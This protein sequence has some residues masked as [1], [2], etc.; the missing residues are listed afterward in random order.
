VGRRL[1]LG[2]LGLY[3]DAARAMQ[4]RQ[5]VGRARRLVP[6]RVLLAWS[7]PA[8][9]GEFH[10]LAKGLA[11]EA[12]SQS[13]P[14]PAAH[15]AREFAAVGARRAFS[16]SRAFWSDDS[17]GL[18]FLFQL[19][20]FVELPRALDG[21]DSSSALPFW[22]DLIANWLDYFE[23]P[24]QPAWH[25]YPT[26]VR[27]IAWCVALSAE[28][29]DAALRRRMVEALW[30]QAHYLRRSVE[31][32]IGGNH[33]LKN[34]T[35]LAFAGA[36]FPSSA[37]LDR[38]LRLLDRELPRQILADG[39][40]EERSTSYHR[41]V[42]HDLRQVAE[43]LR[44]SGREVTATL[45]DAIDR[46]ES[47]AQAIAGPD[48][49]LPLLNDA[50]EGPPLT[51]RAVE[52]L[53][54]LPASGHVVMRHGSDQAVFDCGPLAP[55]HLPPHAHA[56]ALSVVAWFEGKPLL[57]DRGA[58]AYSG[59]QREPFRATAAHNTV[60][61]ER[62]SQ[63]VFWGD[64]RASR[65]PAVK[66][67]AV[68]RVE[69][70]VLVSA[71]H[72]GYRRLGG[73]PIHQRVLVWLPGEGLLIID[74]LDSLHAHNVRSFLHLAPSVALVDWSVGGL[75]VAALGPLPTGRLVERHA[76]WLGT[77]VAAETMVQE[78]TV[79]PRMP[80]GWSLLRAGT[81]VNTLDP[82][83]VRLERSS[84]TVLEL[85]LPWPSF[86]PDRVAHCRKL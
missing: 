77:E 76:P 20:G 33:V 62:Q 47:W 41:E 81:A 75:S 12:A 86:R 4:W 38:A 69:G 26:S 65:L 48:L 28:D 11:A 66:L 27:V 39:A 34:A 32:D 71:S 31:H 54:V 5:A 16:P 63:C 13:A 19:H 59:P 51:R 17:D 9:V 40:H 46:A 30:R 79:L 1:I 14:G 7:A 50:W 18:L 2:R 57:V 58:S 3:A 15:D 82:H 61:I 67:S 24:E 29:W 53:T 44:R 68:Q 35:A 70:A 73:E 22:S 74:R 25:P 52:D 8:R 60:E 42:L 23:R 64:F 10:P 45:R 55:P 78:G 80:F 72:D 21:H 83:G 36:C 85:E 43:L 84:G 6:P 56:D 37:L 49:K